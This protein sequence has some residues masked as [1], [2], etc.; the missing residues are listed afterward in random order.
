[1]AKEYVPKVWENYKTPILDEDLNHIEKGLKEV[2]DGLN[3]EIQ[4]RKSESNAFKNDL[5]SESNVREETDN[6]LAEMISS[7]ATAR[8]ASVEKESEDRKNAIRAEAQER[9][10]ADTAINKKLDD[11]ASDISELKKYELNVD[12][13]GYICIAYRS[14]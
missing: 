11:H 13:E 4:N 6:S 3:S 12:S 9:M 7:E 2:T 14:A 8:V 1:M 10:N 5:R